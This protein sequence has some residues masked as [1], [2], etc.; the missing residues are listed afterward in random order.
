MDEGHE[1]WAC[2]RCQRGFRLGLRL[3]LPDA[4]ATNVW[5]VTQLD[6]RGLRPLPRWPGWV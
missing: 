6:G 4:V 2:D 5:L 3:A 1:A